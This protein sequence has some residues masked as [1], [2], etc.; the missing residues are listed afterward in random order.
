MGY[1][2]GV[3]DNV[4][5]TAKEALESVLKRRLKAGEEVY[6]LKTFF[7]SGVLTKKDAQ[8]IAAAEHNPLIERASVLSGAEYASKAASE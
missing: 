5:K 1:L 4:G 2:P 3:T 7:L 8:R 6:A